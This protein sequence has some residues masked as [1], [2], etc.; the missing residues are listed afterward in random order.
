MTISNIQKQKFLST[1]Y[2]NLF[3]SGNKPNE[4]EVLK[5]FSEYF[6]DY[7]AGS[8]LPI[9][10]QI[11][12]QLS[13]GDT[14]VMNQRM[15]HT[16]FN[17]ETLYDSLFENSNDMMEITTA[18]N[19]RL[20]NLKARRI[21]LEQ[22][23]DDLI[24]ANQ[25]SDGYYSVY[26]DNF[27]T[28]NNTDL[29]LTDSFVDTTFGKVSLPTLSS[30]V[31]DL[32]STSSIIST[33]PTY[34][35]SFNQNQIE[36]EKQFSDN[37][38]FGSVFDGLENT[39]WQ[40]IFY[41]KSIGLV[42]FGITLPIAK[43]VILSKIE[44][45]LNTIS[46]TEIYVKINY[47]NAQKTYEVL[48]KKS[49]KDYDRFSFS[50]DPGNVGSIELYLIKTE[51]D[52]IE[53]QR[54]E[55]YGYRFGIRDIVISGQ[56]FDK[57]SSYVSA[58]ISLN[59]ND[60]ER[61]IIDAVS[62]ETGEST[63]LGTSINYFVAEDNPNA[64]SI[65]D[66]SWTPISP[67]LASQN[68]YSSIVNFSGTNLNSKKIVS[69]GTG[70]SYELIK[71]PL[72]STNSTKTINNQNPILD[73]FPNQTIYRIAAIEKL[74]KPLTSYILEGTNL[75]SGYYVNYRNSIFNER[76][77]LSTWSSILNNQSSV[78]QLFKI[79]PYQI[80][81]NSLFFTGPNISGISI[82]LEAKVYCPND[83]VVKHLFTKND[84]NSKDWDV[85]IYLNGRSTII[86][87]GVSSD[88]VEWNFK[89][90]QNIIKIA[91]DA[92]NSTNGSI[93]LMDSKSLLDYGLVYSD[94]YTYVDPIEFKVNRSI[95]DKVYTVEN[96]FGNLEIF[97][98]TNMRE[99]S[100]IFY[101][102]STS[103]PVKAIRF[104]AD[105]SRGN[106]PLVSPSLDY[107]KVKFK[108]SSRITDP[109]LMSLSSNNSATSE[110]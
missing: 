106:N 21:A 81:N 31:F 75:I 1:L 13:F 83:I 32:I 92:R 35:L 44:G 72:A 18:L 63:P 51:P 39:E 97:S 22:K 15:L 45:R 88:T 46:P 6:S 77:E 82:L 55:K 64:Q 89:A 60:N 65:S 14:D 87:S 102:S 24:F 17:I 47:A 33:S 4:A 16:I 23:I 38:F 68:S 52:V 95:F 11:F 30:S 53:Q 19:K 78:Q 101:F 58:P 98:R 34:S 61:L 108:N 50:F 71:I 93:N 5:T 8:P 96:Y 62:V 80:T 3:S 57:T 70:S 2:K 12:R 36:T 42:T 69:Q 41:F 66:F 103:N 48:N 27:S 29:S 90:G 25:N 100:R 110:N 54:A 37:S 104:R 43:N 91:I 79:P 74:E 99:N 9:N 49:T 76:D 84:S 109:D 67:A 10:G 26:S 56:Y 107:F 20:E 28:T 94:Y 59:D 105:L 40:Q 85:A 7:E 73:L 86:P